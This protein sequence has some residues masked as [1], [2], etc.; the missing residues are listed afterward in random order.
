MPGHLQASGPEG[1]D[2][3]AFGAAGLAVI[4]GL[5]YCRRR[6][7]R[8]LRSPYGIRQ[9]PKAPPARLPAV[10]IPEETVRVLESADPRTL[11]GLRDSSLLELLYSTGMRK[12]ELVA[13]NLADFSFEKQEVTILKSKSTKG[14]V[15]P[16]GEYAR[17]FTEAYI[18]TVR[19]VGQIVARAA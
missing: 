18:R 13:L 12:G 9:S 11:L 17:H 7:G 8:I 4:L 6:E 3:L 15:V 10:L 14:R 16:V 19:T 2:N 1:Q 5:D